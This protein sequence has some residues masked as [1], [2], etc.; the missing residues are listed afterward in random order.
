MSADPNS[1]L[2]GV[3]KHLNPAYSAELTPSRLETPA[4]R[5]PILLQKYVALGYCYI[6]RLNYNYHHIMRE[7][8][9]GCMVELTKYRELGS[10]PIDSVK[11]RKLIRRVSYF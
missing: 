2:Y 7:P 3:V 4:L 8:T 10:I 5:D 6:R 11:A 1:Y 9:D